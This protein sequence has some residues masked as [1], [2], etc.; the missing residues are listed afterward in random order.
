MPNGATATDCDGA[1]DTHRR[2]VVTMRT[3]WVFVV[4]YDWCLAYTN[5]FR[6]GYVGCDTWTPGVTWSTGSRTIVGRRV[7]DGEQPSFH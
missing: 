6:E 5:S 3:H 4:P 7:Y 1:Q 2:D